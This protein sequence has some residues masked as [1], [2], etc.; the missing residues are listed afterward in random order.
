MP[1]PWPSSA[2]VRDSNRRRP[3]WLV[4]YGADESLID[5][6][7]LLTSE[8]VTNCVRHARIPMVPRPD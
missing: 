5:D 1:F 2:T 4:D 6:A 8:L 3:T 7:R